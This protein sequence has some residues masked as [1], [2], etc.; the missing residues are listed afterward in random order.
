MSNI[1]RQIRT[2]LPFTLP[3]LL[4]SALGLHLQSNLYFFILAGLGLTGTKNYTSHL[5]LFP[6]ASLLPLPWSTPVGRP[7][8]HP[9]TNH[10]CRSFNMQLFQF[11]FCASNPTPESREVSGIL[12]HRSHQPKQVPCP[13]TWRVLLCTGSPGCIRTLSESFQNDTS[14]CKDKLPVLLVGREETGH[15]A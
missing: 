1:R 15:E 11:K 9:H 8:F 5:V 6:R 3:Q 4:I 2:E 12:Q 7:P 10:C 13:A 14:S